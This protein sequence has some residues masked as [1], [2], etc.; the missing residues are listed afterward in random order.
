[1]ARIFSTFVEA[2]PGRPEWTRLYY[3]VDIRMRGW[4][5]GF[6]ED[7]VRSQGVKRATVWVKRE[8]EAEQRRRARGKAAA[9]P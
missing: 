3:S 4:V 7:I 5:P 8:A 6:V 9:T 2:H 1:M